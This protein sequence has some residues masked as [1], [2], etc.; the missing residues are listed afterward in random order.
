MNSLATRIGPVLANGRIAVPLTA[1]ICLIL[2]TVILK[3]VIQLP[4][5]QLSS[6]ILLFIIIYFGFIISFPFTD[7]SR[8]G[9]SSPA[10]LWM[11]AIILATLG[12]IVVYAI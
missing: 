3:N 11:G 12:I 7:T 5:T 8:H 10:M 2:L 6:D 1:G 4:A 9:S